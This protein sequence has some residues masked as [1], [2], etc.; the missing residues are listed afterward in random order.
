MFYGLNMERAIW[1]SIKEFNLLK[2]SEWVRA[3]YWMGSLL[4]W[5]IS[6]KSHPTTYA[7]IKKMN[8][9]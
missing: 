1:E 5:A 2:G 3:A 8:G 4:R 9:A 6:I 7:P